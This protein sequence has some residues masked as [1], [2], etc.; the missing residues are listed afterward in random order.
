VG[1][2][3]MSGSRPDEALGTSFE[4]SFRALLLLDVSNGRSMTASMIAAYDFIAVYGA[5]FGLLDENLHGDGVFRFSEFASRGELT[6]NAMK[7]LVLK[8]FVNVAATKHGFAYTLSA[9]GRTVSRKMQSDYAEEYRIAAREV[10]RAF[11][12]QTDE[13][14]YNKIQKRILESVKEG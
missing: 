12:R 4:M 2:K 10:L 9:E 13:Q 14:L 11:G 3:E 7:E 8:R 5:D 1:E 6:Q